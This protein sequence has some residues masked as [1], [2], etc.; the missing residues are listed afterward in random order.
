MVRFEFLRSKLGVEEKYNRRERTRFKAR[1]G[2]AWRVALAGVTC[3]TIL[4]V[5]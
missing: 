5:K 4:G 1:E 3:G 2:V